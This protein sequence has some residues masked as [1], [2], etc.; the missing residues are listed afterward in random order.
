MK[1]TKF[2][3]PLLALASAIVFSFCHAAQATTVQEIGDAGLLPTTAQLSAGSGSIDA[4]RGTLVT[5]IGDYAD[6]FRVYLQS[7]SLFTATTTGSSFAYNNFDT[8]LFLFD[9]A[10]LGVVANDDDP[11]VGPTSTISYTAANA[12]YYFLAIAGA[13]YTPVSASG[14]IFGNLTGQNQVGPTGP[15]GAGAL[16]NWISSTSEGDDYEILL[17]GAA[18]GPDG[19]AD[20]PEPASLLLTAMG[21]GVLSLR[22]RHAARRAV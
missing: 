3:F 11:S 4:I 13:G 19:A 21:L 5:P 15:G 17:S 1:T 12:G 18:A 7:N 14:A 22:R 9:S 16:S 2:R 20:V 6:L 8:S 10:G